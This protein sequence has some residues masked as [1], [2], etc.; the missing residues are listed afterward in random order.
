MKAILKKHIINARGKHLKQKYIIFESDDWGAIRI[1]DIQTR[2]DLL[3]NN[4]IKLNDPFS[5]FDTIETSNDYYEL[6]NVLNKHQDVNGQHPIIT[7]NFILNNPD[8]KGIEKVNFEHYIAE[9]FEETYKKNK[10]SEEA[11]QVLQ[12]GIN[13][14]L[15]QPQFHGSEHLNVVRWM[16]YLKSGE[17]SFRYAF[18]KKCF[19][20][21]E[22]SSNNRRHNLMA[23]YDYDNEKELA[24][25]KKNIK[26]GLIQFENIF[27]FKSATTIAPCYVWDKEVEHEMFKGGVL[28]FQ[29]SFLQNYPI[30]EKPF[31]K[32]YHYIGQKNNNQQFYF[33]RNGLFEPSLND[34]VDWISKCLESME[35]AFK[36]GK[37][38]IIGAHR[39]NFVGGLD[40]VQSKQNLQKLDLLLA[41]IIQKWPEV[42]FISSSEL[43]K[44]YASIT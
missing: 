5:R 42:K 30:P 22:K 31:K 32:I 38:A 9:S 34:K 18:N 28:G 44:K 11:F 41:K 35:I 20:I 3:K 26:Q 8:F 33:V 7:A 36:W 21:N 14:N 12:Q 10:G 16:E 4:L 37:P 43:A 2:E 1:P 24:F 23:S 29:G 19:A 25:V 17:E 15:I 40:Q 13:Q 27:G 39:I 6:F